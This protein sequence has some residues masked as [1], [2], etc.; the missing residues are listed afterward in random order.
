MSFS[1]TITNK[2][3]QRGRL[4]FGGEKEISLKKGRKRAFASFSRFAEP[5]FKS[6]FLRK[7]NDL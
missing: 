1:E 7:E 6:P 3:D 2:N 5:G 4:Y